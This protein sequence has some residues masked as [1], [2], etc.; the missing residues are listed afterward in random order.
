VGRRSLSGRI[1]T[2][3]P[4]AT[5]DSR[6][7]IGASRP[8]R[9]FGRLGATLSMI[10]FQHTLFA[11]PFAFTGAVL[12]AGGLPRGRVIAWILGAMVGARSAA[13]VWNRIA[14][15]R[16]DARNPRTAD[17][18]LVTGE[19]GLPFAWG[20][21]LA[22]LLLF[23]LSAAM[24]NPL[25]LALATPA[26]LIILSYSWAKRFTW[27]THMHLGVSLGI[28]PIGGWIAVAGRSHAAP[29][30]LGA[31]VA[32]WVAGFDVLYS[33]QDVEFDRQHG[34][35]SIPARLGIPRALLLARGCH[36][37]TVILLGAVALVLPLGPAWLAGVA[38][39][40]ALLVYEHSLV[41]ADDLSRVNQAFFTI[42]GIV[43]FV[44]L[45]SACA[46]AALRR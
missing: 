40:A 18:P 7:A 20:F 39:T 15:L 31:A 30:L 38:I 28:A 37:L 8:R 12:A 45:A 10:K 26:V 29:L 32:F 33:C 23:Y 41:R 36:V 46:D 5:D 14:D 43:G 6:P 34:L 25:A 17:R 21:L 11:L 16:Y 42:N 27:L 22:S 1:V 44:V 2:G 35:H 3:E 4:A 24:L 13:M 19:L 9:P